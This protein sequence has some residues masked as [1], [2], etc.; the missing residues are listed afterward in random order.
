MGGDRSGRIFISYS[1]KDGKDFAAEMRK[2]L[3]GENL[4]VWHDVVALE[5]GLDWW[6]QIEDA[7]KSKELQHF[8]LIVTPAALESPVVRREIRFARQ[9]GKTVCPVKGPGLGDL[10]ALPRWLGETYDLAVAERRTNF[11]RVLEGE[12][13][14]NRVP[15][16]AP[17][18]PDDF[19][20]R[21]R[22]FQA[23]KQRLLDAKGDAVAAITAALRG[24]GG[25]GKTTLA[26]ALAHDPDIQDAYFDGI[27]WAE[28]GET[29]QRLL[30][31]LS[32]LI[33]L[34]TGE[35][36][37][38]GTV[39]AAAAKLGEALGDRRIL[40]IVDDAW[41][42]QD[43]RPFLHGAPRCVRL[44]TTRIDSVL[45]QTALRQPVDAMQASEALSLLSAGLPPDQVSHERA[46]LAKLAVRLGEWAQLLKIVNGFLRDRVVRTKD[47]LPVAIA[48]ANER[49]D[50]RGLTVFDPRDETDR[51]KAVART[52][53]VSLDLLS[54][55]ERARFGELG[56]FPEDAEIPVGVIAHLWT[57]TGGLEDFETEDLLSRLFDLSLL[58]ELDIGQRFFRL[59]DTTGR[60]LRD[61]ADKEGLVAQHHQQLVGAL[62]SVPS[63]NSD[64]RTRRY[65]YL[66]LPHHLAAAGARESLD[67]LL[68]DP[69]WLKAKLEAT[70]SPSA[71]FADYERY[72]AGKTQ[73]LI[74]RTLRLIT[75]ICARDGRQLLPQLIGRLADT[76]IVSATGFTEEARRLVP[77]PAIL[78]LR[79]TLTPPGPEI[80]RLVGHEYAVTAICVLPD[81]RLASG[82]YDE[83]IRLWN[84]TEGVETACLKGQ[85]KVNA[86]CVLPDG[87]VAAGCDDGIS[88]WDVTSGKQTDHV[89]VGHVNALAVLPDGR[90][91]AAASG[92]V[93]LDINAGVETAPLAGRPAHH[94]LRLLRPPAFPLRPWGRFPETKIFRFPHE[95]G[96]S[97]TSLCVLP[98]GRLASGCWDGS[99]RLWD[100]L[101]G[102]ETA[103]LEGHTSD[104]G[105]LCVLP[106]GRLVSGSAEESD[107]IR[108]WDVA[109]CA[110]TLQLSGCLNFFCALCPLADG[111]LA[112]NSIDNAIVIW[113][114]TTGSES[115]R[116]EGHA[117]K[118]CAICSLP[119]GRLASA[120]G[121]EDNSIR[122]WDL[123]LRTAVRPHVD[124]HHASVESMCAL[125]DRRIA[126]GASD[127]K[128]WILDDKTGNES[129]FLEGHSRK[130]HAL[131]ALPNGQLASGSDD[132]TIRF[133]D[134]SINREVTRL[135]ARHLRVGALHLMPDGRLASGGY[136]GA[137]RIWEVTT[138]TETVC[139]NGLSSGLSSRVEVQCLSFILERWFAVGG[140][141]GN[142]WLCDIETGEWSE[143]SNEKGWV[144]T[145]C[146]LPDGR[147]ASGAGDGKIRLWDVKRGVETGCF[148]KHAGAIYA[149]CPLPDGRL[150]SAADDSTI[151]LWDVG[152]G[153][154]VAFLELATP[155]RAI[156]AVAPKRI[157]TGDAL[158]KLH[159]LEVVD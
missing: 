23:L 133:W 3:E 57:A 51:A 83:T 98:D 154:E 68:L 104:V 139:F 122:V 70:A 2:M 52:I 148:E 8:V 107:R 67:A 121:G 5:G 117:D 35:R 106:D 137:I 42:E 105:G 90:L 97:V 151:R 60:F 112:S 22:E 123:S 155:L 138:G 95:N 59:H 44:V 141:L 53:G 144:R 129:A 25:Y 54:E 145:L 91:A 30:D 99:I 10:A 75:G 76:E 24:A 80:G 130:V 88:L 159:W 56:V 126:L 92:I 12:S 93:L 17:E 150:A 18:P 62:D 47:P 49:L 41:R 34:M 39:N 46:G 14:Q 96:L 40:L 33:V 50:T 4:S 73:S 111:R 102:K 69:G 134:L 45:P 132:D 113:D 81:S 156:T 108:V 36:P 78:P 87:R 120:S 116:L 29:P 135:E 26:K 94:R 146:S 15:M 131:C 27:L 74:G 61:H 114:L 63:E 158:G 143:L 85:D 84:L 124:R 66:Y 21:P 89:E 1:R 128:I 79:P 119:D 77:R 149:L 86:L 82:S 11:I 55:T 110:E 7:L 147:L 142:I 157:V 115:A 19:V 109:T 101:A 43:L 38:L 140:V 9:E 20:Q 58:L 37:A 28:L 6:T 64:A 152:T 103:R 48:G 13:R 71:L 16:M 125:P 31:T 118:V 136:D 72:G 100:I 65:H 32:D 153:I 127:G